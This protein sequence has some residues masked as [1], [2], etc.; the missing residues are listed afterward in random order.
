LFKAEGLFVGLS[1][2]AVTIHSIYATTMILTTLGDYKLVSDGTRYLG[3]VYVLVLIGINFAYVFVAINQYLGSLRIGQNEYLT[4]M[5][6]Y[7][8]GADA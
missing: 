4:I 2:E 6:D 3:E 1:D 5:S 8:A 7:I